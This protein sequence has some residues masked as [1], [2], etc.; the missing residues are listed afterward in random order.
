M[1][2]KRP[3]IA[4][5]KNSIYLIQGHYG[6]YCGKPHYYLSQS[7]TI[8]W[9]SSDCALETKCSNLLPV[10]LRWLVVG[11]ILCGY[12]QAVRHILHQSGLAV[13]RRNCGYVEPE[14]AV[15]A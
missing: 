7:E 8:S 4:I 14:L 9:A 12:T 2:E 11:N 1:D 6:K 15:I 3:S 5:H 13:S 10:Q